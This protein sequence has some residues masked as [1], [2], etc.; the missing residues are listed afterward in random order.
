MPLN[1]ITASPAEADHRNVD[2]LRQIAPI[3]RAG[4]EWWSNREYRVA[5]VGKRGGL[6]KLASSEVDEFIQ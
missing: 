4:G 3:T 2:L 5:A 6:R 1:V